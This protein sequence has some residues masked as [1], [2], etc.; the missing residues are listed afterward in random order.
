MSKPIPVPV[1]DDPRELRDLA[2]AVLRNDRFPY[3]ASMDGDQPRVRPVSPVK[4]DGF[5]IHIANLR[6]YHKT[7]ELAVNPK[8][9]LCY[10]DPD[11]HQL[12]ITGTACLEHDREACS[13]DA[14]LC[15]GGAH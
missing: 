5:T 7:Q 14:D 3:L 9:E 4:T 8:V 12:R 10:L 11:H 1:P 13:L 6:S 15:L 2:L